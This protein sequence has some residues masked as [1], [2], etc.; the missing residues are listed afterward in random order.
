[1]STT[2]RLSVITLLLISS[3][4]S[5]QPADKKPAESPDPCDK[6]A[7]QMEI[8]NCRE[9]QAQK[10]EA[11][12][13]ALYQK[14]QK[15]M[16]AEMVAED[17]SMK[18]YEERALEK[19]K[20]AQIAWSHYRDAQCAAE[21][22]QCEGGTIAPSVHAGCTEDLANRRMDDLRQTYAIYLQPQ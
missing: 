21:E 5:Q 16:Q 15:A 3:A 17:A 2:L 13:A 14:I 6:A 9:E 20:A 7:T 12:L 11:R 19:L 1:M 18:G 22:Q 10:A 8:T 4:L